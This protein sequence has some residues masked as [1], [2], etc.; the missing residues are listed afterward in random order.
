MRINLWKRHFLFGLWLIQNHQ[1]P[2]SLDCV[3]ELSGEILSYQSTI[4]DHL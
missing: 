3:R 1:T 4:E 2:T